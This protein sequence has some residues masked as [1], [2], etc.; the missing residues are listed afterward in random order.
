MPKVYTLKE[1]I[2]FNE[3]G[4]LGWDVIP[5]S[6]NLLFFKIVEQPLD[7]DLPNLLLRNFYENPEWIK[8]FYNNHKK[9]I[10]KQIGLKY[11]ENNNIIMSEK[12]KD[13]LTMWNLEVDLSD[14]LW[15]GFKCL[16]PYNKNTLYNKVILDKYCKEEIEKL[17]EADLIEEYEVGDA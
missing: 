4:K 2:D 15:L 10:S 7:S 5:N 13:T 12:F 11:D 9:E 17:K 1:D 6:N 14:C 8:R 16:D 3:L